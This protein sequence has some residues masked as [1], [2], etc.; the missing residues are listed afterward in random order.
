LEQL[1]RSEEDTAI[2]I[3]VKHYFISILTRGFN[4]KAKHPNKSEVRNTFRHFF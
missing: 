2:M 4:L 3:H 1:T